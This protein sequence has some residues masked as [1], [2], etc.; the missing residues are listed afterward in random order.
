MSVTYSVN[1]RDV[2]ANGGIIVT[3]TCTTGTEGTVESPVT[4][5]VGLELGGI[6]SFGVTVTATTSTF[7]A[8]TLQAWLYEPFLGVWTRIPDLDLNVTAGLAVQSF[9]GCTV[10]VPR[11]MAVYLPSGLGVACTVQLTGTFFRGVV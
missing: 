2:I 6:R 5:E 9:P 7:S 1:R 10:T 8:G 4:G 11:G 3:G